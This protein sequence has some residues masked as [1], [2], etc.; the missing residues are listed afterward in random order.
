MV[1]RKSKQKMITICDNV[2]FK[3]SCN[4]PFLIRSVTFEKSVYKNLDKKRYLNDILKLFMINPDAYFSEGRDYE[5]N[6]IFQQQIG[7][8]N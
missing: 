1:F 2:S 3:I 4:G 7:G 8:L 5:G 6:V